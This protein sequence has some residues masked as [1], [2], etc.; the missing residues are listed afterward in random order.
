MSNTLV[1]HHQSSQVVTNEF[2][3]ILRSCQNIRVILSY[4]PVKD[5][6]LLEPYSN[7]LLVGLDDGVAVIPASAKSIMNHQLGR[8]LELIITYVKNH[9]CNKFLGMLGLE[10]VDQESQNQDDSSQGDDAR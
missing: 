5:E 7:M 1:E 3:I 10:Q 6:I 8:L 4:S 2:S 9:E